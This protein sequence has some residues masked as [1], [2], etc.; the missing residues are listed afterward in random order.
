[1]SQLDQNREK[2]D[3]TD[4]EAQASLSVS[5]ATHAENNHP[6]AHQ[7]LKITYGH[8]SS[9]GIKNKND[10]TIA[11]HTP[12]EP[13]LT[14][15][16]AVFLIADGVS[17]A[18]MG[19]EAS[20]LCG[21]EFINLYYHTPELWSIKK[22][23][24]NA[25]IALNRQLYAKNREFQEPVRGYATTLSLVIVKSHTAHIFH[26]GDSRIYLFRDNIL[27]QIT[28]D[29]SEKSHDGMTLTRAMGI[30]VTL[31]IDYK[32]VELKEKD[33]FFFS[34]D[35][36]HDFL[37]Q[38]VIEQTI[39]EHNQN[40]TLCC[41]KLGAK[42]LAAKSNDNISCM[43]IQTSELA[44]QNI[45]DLQQVLLSQPF[46]PPLSIGNKLDGYRVIQELHASS[47]SQV[48]LVVDEETDEK[49]VMKTPSVNYDDDQSYIDRFCLEEW[50]GR[51]IK[52]QHIV[53]IITPK[54]HKSFL[55][56]LMEYVEGISLETWMEKNYYPRGGQVLKIAQQIAIGVEALHN[57]EIIHRD[58]KP[59][60]IMIDKHGQVKIVDFGSIYIASIA[61][62]QTP[63]DQNELLGTI[64]Y[65]APEYR[66]GQP[67]HAKMDQFSLGII[68]YE[69][70]THN[71]PYS[72]N[73]MKAQK[74]KEFKRLRYTLSF[75]YNAEIPIWFD[76][77]LRKA[78]AINHL[79]R[80]DNLSDFAYD[81]GNPNPEFLTKEYIQQLEQTLPTIN[82]YWGL[83]FLWAGSL[84]LA[85][86]VFIVQ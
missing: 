30:D 16:G 47:R 21:N 25:L 32:T 46:P 7:E 5:A 53:K 38:E 83:S 72:N 33:C 2:E 37:T 43:I 49:L 75:K 9:A 10:D 8:F 39:K 3:S 76:A 15:K 18:E 27:K 74:E 79:D 44:E 6:D 28:T 29:H 60:N 56:Y 36:I 34:T 20:Q 68:I 42:A 22:S 41:E 86:L 48:Y 63:L 77:A 71:F 23:V 24:L 31:N 69:M 26:I 57:N 40:F 4:K 50:V 78:T 73:F 61:E 62:I 1:M 64:N 67:A 45:D 82:L 12:S 70:L 14:T 11:A 85:A 59:A 52:N 81:L 35:G 84:F 80:Y 58:L 13:Q 51:R 19:R 66:L 17:T 65:T 54:R 55:Y